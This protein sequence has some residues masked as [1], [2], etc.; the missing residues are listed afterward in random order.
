M[1]KQLSLPKG[2]KD[3]LGIVGDHGMEPEQDAPKTGDNEDQQSDDE[4]VKKE[5]ERLANEKRLLREL[6]GEGR[7]HLVP[8][9]FRTLMYLK[10]QKKEFSVIFRSFGTELDPVIWEYN[11][12]C[13]GE[14]P[15]F[16]GRNNTPL[17][18]LDGSKNSKDMRI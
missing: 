7:Y 14:H 15:C 8:S 17:V 2:A 10:K 13:S 5:K 3:E 9:F 4:D 1:L 11:K 16:N 6:Y 18:K 12:F